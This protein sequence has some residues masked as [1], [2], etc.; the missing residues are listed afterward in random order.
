MP[1]PTVAFNHGV[2]SG[3]PYANS[4]ILWTRITPPQDFKEPI[5]GTWQA[6]L[7]AGFEPGSIVDSGTFNTSASRDWTV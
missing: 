3:D 1:S 4:V 6:S 2:A 7:S 5:D